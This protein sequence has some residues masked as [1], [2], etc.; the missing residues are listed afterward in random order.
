MGLAHLVDLPDG[1]VDGLYGVGV[2]GILGS[3]FVILVGEFAVPRASETA[4]RAA[5]DI[6]WGAFRNHFW[7]G[8][9]LL[10][11]AVPLAL[12]LS[13]GPRV[14]MPALLAAMVGMFFYGYAFIMAPQR[15]PNS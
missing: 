2:A 4:T 12:L 3:L 7:L 14:G 5:R 8:G 10:G 11:H 9:L 1:W 6:Q 15:I 13:M